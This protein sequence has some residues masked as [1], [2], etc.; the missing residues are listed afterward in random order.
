MQTA[1]G[2]PAQ[3][4][5]VVREKGNCKRNLQVCGPELQPMKSMAGGEVGVSVV[6]W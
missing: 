5:S 2:T 6:E 4:L 3:T 1:N